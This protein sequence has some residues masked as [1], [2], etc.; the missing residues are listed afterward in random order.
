[1]TEEQR[2][3]YSIHMAGKVAE[4]VLSLPDVVPHLVGSELMAHGYAAIT[5]VPIDR[6]RQDLRGIATAAMREAS[7]ISIAD[8]VLN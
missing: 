1:M 4:H 3:L 5:G 2:E 8:R 6:A 7:K